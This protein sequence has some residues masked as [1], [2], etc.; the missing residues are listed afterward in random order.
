MIP[1]FFLGG[2]GVDKAAGERDLPFFSVCNDATQVFPRDVG[3]DDARGFP[4]SSH[5]FIPLRPLWLI[6]TSPEHL[7]LCL[8]LS[9]I[10]FPSPWTSEEPGQYRELR[11]KRQPKHLE[12][13]VEGLD[14]PHRTAMDKIPLLH[15]LLSVDF[16]YKNTFT[17]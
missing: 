13:E 3:N 7:L 9:Y 10:P 8:L 15:S 1:L 17:L 6:L 2:G 4:Q 12:R 11:C 5:F 14:S 16:R